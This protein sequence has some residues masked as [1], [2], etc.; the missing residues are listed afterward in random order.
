MK[1]TTEVSGGAAI[2]RSRLSLRRKQGLIGWAFLLIAAGLIV[3]MN[4]YPMVRGFMLSLQ[5]GVG[6]RMEYSG[7]VNYSRMIGDP[8][9]RQTL[10]TTFTYLLVQVP[11]MLL[12]G[13]A[14]ASMLNNKGLKGRGFFRTAIFLPCA[15]GLVAY[16]LVFRQMFS[17][18]GL[19]NTIL[20]S[21]GILETGHNWL[22]TAWSAQLV[23]ILGLLW[24]WTGFNMIFYLAGIQNIDSSIYDAARIDGA[25]VFQQFW[26]ITI[27]LLRPIILL[28]AIMSTNGTLQLFDE[29]F[30]LTGGGPGISSMSMSHYIF[31]TA[32]TGNPTIGYA[33]A[34]SFMVFLLVAILAFIQLKVGDRR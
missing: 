17:F 14:L 26:K 1:Q 6:A 12:M 34:M 22:G 21:S 7:F 13:L 30:N 33:S 5:T 18:D 24:R 3:M 23:I 32:F 25:N 29:S 28:T 31:N 15:V 2:K 4:F 9:F 10:I 27:P 19:I 20:V 16:S 8:R 11:I